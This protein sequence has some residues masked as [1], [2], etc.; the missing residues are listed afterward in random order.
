MKKALFKYPLALS[1]VVFFCA[2]TGPARPQNPDANPVQ[3]QCYMENQAFQAGEELT[4]KIYYNW[5]FI[6]LSAGEVTF[7]VRE[8]GDQYHF[9]AVGKTYKSYE[10]FY[11]VRDYYDC[12]VD[13][14]SMLPV[15]SVRDIQEG[16][17]T[18][19]D[20]IQFDQ[21]KRIATSHRGNSLAEAKTDV[22]EMDDCMHDILSIFYFSRNINF[23]DFAE[24][25][26]FPVKIFIDKEIFPLNVKY[27]GREADKKIKKEG[28]FNTIMFSPEVIA[29]RVFKKGSQMKVW[30]SD[31]ANRI[32]LQIESPVSVGSI[33]VVLKD[34]KNLRYDL[35]AQTK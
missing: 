15:V 24:G 5:N 7:K 11:K 13:K 1:L 16:K 2:F 17:Y 35:T 3:N 30:V 19:Y 9:S 12:Y 33:K 18:L 4:Y 25:E 32:P 14:Q 21:K 10:W 26:H 31:D 23:S 28:R 8:V 20:R 29:G 6:W 27:L 34:H 22:Y